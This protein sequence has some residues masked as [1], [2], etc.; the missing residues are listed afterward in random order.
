METPSPPPVELAE[1]QSNL[2]ALLFLADRPIS[3]EKLQTLLALQT[4]PAWLPSSLIEALQLLQKRYQE[5][6]HGIE[7]MEVAGGYQLRTKPG[8]SLLAQKLVKT[9]V[10]RLSAGAMETLAILAYKQPMMK[11]EIDQI[12]G[13]DSSYFIRGL[14]EKKLVQISGR[15]E[16]PGR[17]LLYATTEQFLEVFGLKDLS[18][19]PSLREIEQM[20]PGSESPNPDGETPQT[21]ELRRMVNAMNL[22]RTSDLYYNPKE[23]E[24]ILKE[25]REKVASIATSSPYLDE[26]QA[27]ELQA[28]ELQ[29]PETTL[30]PPENQI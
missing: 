10:Q 27:T 20:I 28:T 11:E 1:I 4:E 13:V 21:R 15:S 3:L 23:D 22:D 2:E 8:R 29:Q 9:V 5:P 26:L 18:A 14:M 7:L 19:L 6:C 12:R 30:P 17:P 24:K 25:I 16:L